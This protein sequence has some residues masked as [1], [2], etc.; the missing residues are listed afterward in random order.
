LIRSFYPLEIKNLF[1]LSSINAGS[2]VIGYLAFF[3]PGGLGVKDGA[4]ALAFQKIVPTPIATMSAVISRIFQIILE[5][6]FSLV[7]VIFDREARK[8]LVSIFKR[9]FIQSN[10]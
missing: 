1:L 10:E 7:F 3:V 8:F 6:L 9:K 5:I 4:Y 2:W